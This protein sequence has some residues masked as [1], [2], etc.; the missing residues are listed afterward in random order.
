MTDHCSVQENTKVVHER[1][2]KREPQ[3]MRTCHTVSKL[4]GLHLCRP[5][6]HRCTNECKLT[7]LH[8]CL[9]RMFGPLALD[10]RASPPVARGGGGWG[11]RMHFS[12]LIWPSAGNCCACELARKK[13]GWHREEVAKVN[14]KPTDKADWP[15]VGGSLASLAQ[16]ILA[17]THFGSI[18]LWPGGLCRPAPT[19]TGF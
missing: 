11:D 5:S 10:G 13:K 8:W 18:R 2:A 9:V 19:G 12:C 7:V 3:G 14:H 6:Q 16:A 1:S 17:Q 15:L 4:S